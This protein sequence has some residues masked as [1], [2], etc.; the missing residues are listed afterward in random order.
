MA[1]DATASNAGGMELNPKYDQYDYPIISPNKASGHPGHLDDKQMK[2]VQ[3]LRLKLESAGY[4]DRLDILTLVCTNPLF[5]P[6]GERWLTTDC[7]CDSC[8]RASSMLLSPRRCEI[9]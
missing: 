9:L 1:A 2:A 6:P 3:E 8:E 4:T 5:Q 7:S